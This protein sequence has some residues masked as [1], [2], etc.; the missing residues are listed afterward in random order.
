MKKIAIIM[1]SCIVMSGIFFSACSDMLDTTV[2]RV[3]P[4]EAKNNDSIYS[5]LGL[6]TQINQLADQYVVVGELRGDLM[7]I[8]KNADEHL[9][10]INNFDY[11]YSNLSS[12]PYISQ[13]EYYSVINNCN[14]FIQ[15]IDPNVFGAEKNTQTSELAVVH[16]F[17]A[18]T[19][20]Q[21]VL[22]YGEA[23]Y[24]K[25]PILSLEDIAHAESAQ[26]MQRDELFLQLL[27][28]IL[29]YREVPYEIGLPLYGK[30]ELIE[31][32]FRISQ[33]AGD[34]YLWL[35]INQPLYA[36]SAVTAYY[37]TIVKE[38]TL[39]TPSMSNR[40]YD[41]NFWGTNVSFS[42]RWNNPFTMVSTPS[43]YVIT[44]I[45]KVGGVSN[46]EFLTMGRT[47][48]SSSGGAD[49]YKLAPSQVAMDIWDRQEYFYYDEKA[50][51]KLITVFGDVRGK[52]MSTSFSTGS[53]MFGDNNDDVQYPVIVKFATG[54]VI[55]SRPSTLYL[56]F[57]EALNAAG[58]PTLAFSVL[59]YGL[60]EK[61]LTDATKVDKV[62]LD[63]SIPDNFDLFRQITTPEEVCGIHALGCG[64]TEKDDAIYVLPSGTY[65]NPMTE[66]EIAARKEAF[67]KDVYT[68][69]LVEYALETAFEGSR[70]QDLMRF[71][72]RLGDN[73]ILA[74][75][76]AAK[77]KDDAALKTKLMTEAN[78]Y[79]P[80]NKK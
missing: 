74:A 19:Y 27:E 66:E 36:Q 5:V 58:K 20:M 22:N 67:Q 53:Y 17:R 79:L 37:Y 42:D 21:L 10:A 32:Y 7:D 51:I 59:K 29:P 57:A 63:A 47:P 8:T 38:R 78:W 23:Y 25:K 45:P 61:I 31:H 76:V 50:A 70:F 35:S 9:R 4:T 18:W 40:W 14:Y 75:A 3:L 54:K 69:L 60:S 24:M 16:A 34:M 65:S 52:S 12:N 41:T 56:H 2:N 30:N 68:K 55:L 26:P 39:I 64:N 48:S 49:V 80:K 11:N 33:L 15:N 62:E 1:V 71:S 28:D 43:P 13:R 44:A 77:H 72:L 46:L 6:L 73:E